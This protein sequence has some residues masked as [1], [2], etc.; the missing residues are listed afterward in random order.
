MIRIIWT[1]RKTN[2]DIL[3]VANEQ[4][5]IVPGLKK[6]QAKFID[7]V[8]QKRKLEDIVKTGNI[9]GKRDRENN[10]KRY[11]TA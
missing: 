5:I 3:I 4:R 7:H 2:T 9:C 6:R 10:E 1:A 11:S 8:L